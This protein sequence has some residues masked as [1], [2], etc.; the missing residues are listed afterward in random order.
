MRERS[1]V[2]QSEIGPW[3]ITSY[4]DCAHLLREPKLTRRFEDSWEQ[5]A[6]IQDSVGRTWFEE[7]SRWMLWLDPPD[8]TRLRG[9]VSKAFTPRYV[10]T[11]HWQVDEIVAGL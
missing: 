4:E 1:P 5:R 2:Y 10:G 11:L 3:F 6:V 8:H 7:Q 9:L